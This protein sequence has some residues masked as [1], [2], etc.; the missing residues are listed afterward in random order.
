MIIKINW[1]FIINLAILL[2]LANISYSNQTIIINHLNYEP[3][4]L[5]I[6][7]LNEIRNK[8]ILFG[9]ASVGDNIMEGLANLAS[10]NPERYNLN[11]INNPS[12]IEGYAFGHW[13]WIN[14]RNGYANEKI[15]EFE[16][17]IRSN[18]SSGNQWGNTLDFAFLKFCFADI[19][20]EKNV[21]E[22][23]N[24][25]ISCVNRLKQDYPTC[26]FIFVTNPNRG[27]VYFNYQKFDAIKRYE[28]NQMIRNYIET[29]GGFLF[30]IADL[31]EHDEN[32][33]LQYFEYANEN[34]PKMWYVPENSDSDGWS[35]DGGHLNN[36][37]KNHIALSMWSLFGQILNN[38]INCDYD[39]NGILEINDAI[40]VM[41]IINNLGNNVQY[42]N[43][44]V[45]G[46]NNIG[47]EEVIY[48]LQRISLLR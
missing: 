29:N 43:C 44:D 1:Y 32:M 13:G 15:I 25:Y 40:I 23:F 16:N 11:I 21:T 17:K 22:I 8:K 14:S 24:N 28:L 10:S 37:G 7:I 4:N 34:Y 12:D 18:T 48:I 9:H 6:S 41:K 46:D 2:I 3:S 30:D 35:Y 42:T 27:D 26:K 5:N 45:N 19:N 31:E 33:N 47:I 39:G 20:V 36:K 38:Q